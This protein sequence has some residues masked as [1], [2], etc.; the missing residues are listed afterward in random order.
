LATWAKISLTIQRTDGGV[1]DAELIRRLAWVQSYDLQPGTTMS[2]HIEELKIDGNAFITSID[3]CPVIAA[4]EGSVVTARF[5]TRQVDELATV[6]ILGPDGETETLTGT[7]IHPIWSV[8]R[9]DWVELAEL[10][11]GESLQAASGIATVLSVNVLHQSTPVYNFEV[12]GEHVYQVGA[13]GLLVHNTTPECAAA[14]AKFPGSRV[15]SLP[16]RIA[17]GGKEF[18]DPENLLRLGGKF[19]WNDY[20][21]ILVRIENGVPTLFEGMTRVELALRAGIKEL[22]AFFMR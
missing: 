18:A 7:T 17:P 5:M 19:D 13:L 8:D 2:M 14:L 9:Q 22:P 11:E 10:E 16:L 3:P 4:G 15:V 20:T 1:V 21:P 6:T 12:H